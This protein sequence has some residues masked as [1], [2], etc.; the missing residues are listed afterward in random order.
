[1]NGFV[2][3]KA[4][5]E[6]QS[7]ALVGACG[8]QLAHRWLSVMKGVARLSITAS[9][10]CCWTIGEDERGQQSPS[11]TISHTRRAAVW[12]SDGLD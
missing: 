6:I 10:L 2:H 7:E 1:M 3:I 4:L 11:V 12:S 5:T 8:W 9:R